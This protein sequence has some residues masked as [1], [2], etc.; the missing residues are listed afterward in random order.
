MTLSNSC[1]NV[2]ERITKIEFDIYSVYEE[3]CMLEISKE[4]EV[5]YQEKKKALIDRLS[6]LK[7]VEDD[8][9][10]YFDNNQHDLGMACDLFEL[11][12]SELTIFA[13]E[14]AGKNRMIKQRVYEILI[15][16]VRRSNLGNLSEEEKKNLLT[17][18]FDAKFTSSIRTRYVLSL[19]AERKKDDFNQSIISFLITLFYK[20]IYL[21]KEVE[22]NLI[23]KSFEDADQSFKQEYNNMFD[24]LN[25]K[26]K[27]EMNEY[28]L[29]SVLLNISEILA[30]LLFAVPGILTTNCILKFKT[31]LLYISDRDILNVKELVMLSPFS[32]EAVKGYILINI[33]DVLEEKQKEKSESSTEFS[34]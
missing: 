23:S 32:S 33:S 30:E 29:T 8:E 25:A 13:D 1:A 15:G 4:T 7:I 11:S 27:K 17:S 14:T 19:L 26:E 31:W 22:D 5:K 21:S 3:L 28:M 34:F 16:Y 12:D 6:A 24:L 10:S 20:N 9:F 2:L 18:C